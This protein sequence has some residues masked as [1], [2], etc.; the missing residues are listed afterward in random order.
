MDDFNDVIE[1]LKEVGTL[2]LELL[3]C[4]IISMV[5]NFEKKYRYDKMKFERVIE[6]IHD[7]IALRCPA[8]GSDSGSETEDS[9]CSDSTDESIKTCDIKLID[10][11]SD[12]EDNRK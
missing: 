3:L 4:D 7:E 8:S 6:A 2:G 10:T 1:S 12:E 9:Y 5:S 11:Y